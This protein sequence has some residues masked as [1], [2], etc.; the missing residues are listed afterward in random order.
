MNTKYNKQIG[1]VILNIVL[2]SSIYLF[3]AVE[4]SKISTEKMRFI[5]KTDFWPLGGFKSCKEKVFAGGYIEF[6][7]KTNVFKG[8]DIT[9]LVFY[10]ILIPLAVFAISLLIRKQTE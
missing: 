5:N 10:S 8:Y 2:Q 6:D 3:N 9:E 4:I 1:I 7:C